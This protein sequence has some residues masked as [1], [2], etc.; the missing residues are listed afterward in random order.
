MKHGSERNAIATQ[1]VNILYSSSRDDV[2]RNIDDGLSLEMI[3][4]WMMFLELKSSLK[5]EAGKK[6]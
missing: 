4:S 2:E 6:L 3:V 1:S 5:T